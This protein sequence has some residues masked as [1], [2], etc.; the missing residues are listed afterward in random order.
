VRPTR[1]SRERAADPAHQLVDAVLLVMQ[2]YGYRDARMRAA[3]TR[4]RP[5]K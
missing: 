1:Q 3:F 4:R 5:L 2:R